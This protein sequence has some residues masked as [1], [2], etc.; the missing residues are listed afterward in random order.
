M[1]D[2]TLTVER[3]ISAPPKAVFDAWL[4]PEMLKRF[5]MPEPNMSVPRASSDA[6]KGGRFE[7]IME[8]DGQELPHGGTYQKIV[9]HSHI[10]FTW[11]SAWSPEDSLV[12][13]DFVPEK[14]GTRVTLKH[15]RFLDQQRRDNHERGWT[16]ILAAFDKMA[17]QSA[18]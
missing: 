16:E 3:L 10:S 14:D 7:I 15:T 11:E 18:A 13:L 4:D 12:E 9:P 2:L 8:A 5:M 1:T 17:L 6:R